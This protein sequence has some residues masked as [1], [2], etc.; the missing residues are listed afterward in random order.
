MDDLDKAR[1][2]KDIMIDEISLV[3]EGANQKRF[4]I[5]KQQRSRDMKE[6]IEIMKSLL[7]DELTDEE[8]EEFQKAEL[9][10]NALKAIKSAAKTLDKYKEDLPADVKAALKTLMKYA[11]YGYPPKGEKSVEKAVEVMLTDLEKAGAKLSKA[12]IAEL[13]KIIDICK[14]LVNQKTDDVKKQYKDLPPEVVAELAEAR[15]LKQKVE[16]EEKARREKEDKDWREKIEKTLEAIS[17]GERTSIVGQ[18]TDEDEDDEEMKKGKKEKE[19][20]PT[21]NRAMFPH[22][23]RRRN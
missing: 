18:D 21:L 11:S 12:T 14:K 2:L 1:K 19:M 5:L 6:L 13:N 15:L 16:D 9:S 4:Y 17:K 22:F 10:D 3:E 7:G 20:F 23:Y 8:I